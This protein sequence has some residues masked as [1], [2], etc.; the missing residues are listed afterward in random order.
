MTAEPNAHSDNERSERAV[1]LRRP[2]F[3]LYL[4]IGFVTLTCWPSEALAWVFSEHTEITERAIEKLIE[5]DPAMEARL[6]QLEARAGWCPH[7]SECGE[8]ALRIAVIPALAGDHSCSPSQLQETL[9]DVDGGAT[10]VRDVLL[11]AAETRRNLH[12]AGS[13][14]NRR[15]SIRREMHVS[16]Q[17]ADALYVQR[18]LVDYSHFQLLRESSSADLE[19]YLSFALASSR[20][21]N[22]TATYANYHLQALRTACLAK[23]ITGQ[24]K[25][26]ALQPSL[27]QRALLYELFAL[28]FLEDSFASGHFVGHWGDDATRMGTHDYYARRGLASP[29]WGSPNVLFAAHGDG[30][31]S[32]GELD[33][34]AD[35]VATSLQQVLNPSDCRTQLGADADAALD[36]GDITGAA[37]VNKTDRAFGLP[38]YDSCQARLVP[39]GLDMLARD[40]EDLQR[41]L[42]NQPVPGLRHPSAPRM[43]IEKGAFLGGAAALGYGLRPGE[44]QMFQLK[45]GFRGGFGAA[46]IVDDPLNSQLVLDVAAVSTLPFGDDRRA[47]LGLDVRLRAPGY[48]SLLDGIL[49]LALAERLT[50]KCPFCV[51]W[52][53]SAAGGGLWRLWKSHTLIGTT[54]WQ[55][56]LLRDVTVRWFPG[57]RVDAEAGPAKRL[58]ARIELMFPAFTIRNM[59][60]ISGE[61]VAQSTDL[62][63][64]V[65]PSMLHTS[66]P[67]GGVRFG[68]FVSLTTATRVFP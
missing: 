65:G 37:F 30:F 62:F 6:L 21:S 57:I 22:A 48:V 50:S 66:G 15:E 17:V 60:P 34:A 59:V 33:A 29:R 28:H 24:R 16:L 12:E 53:A 4:L 20:E 35:A 54:S 39:P 3:F 51:G 63:L 56:S 31:I 14:G 8:R 27:E 55:F 67:S 9:A 25:H 41:V 46:G 61:G 45:A 13:D 5:K 32:D 49:A 7:T 38:E 58:P 18:A 36:R 52:A 1:S 68:A 11:V 10:W 40:P 64:D 19:A 43:R 2:G 23:Q 47:R 26:Q 42:Q 44:G